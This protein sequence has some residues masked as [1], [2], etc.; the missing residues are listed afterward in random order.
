MSITKNM[1][2]G[3][4]T[5]VAAGEYT[6]EITNMRDWTGGQDGKSRKAQFFCEVAEP[7]KDAGKKVFFSTWYDKN[8]VTFLEK[9]GHSLEEIFGKS[10]EIDEEKLFALLKGRFFS[11]RLGVKNGYNELGEILACTDTEPKL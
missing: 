6:L 3:D 11:V 5:P 1:L 4:R 9:A 8:I 10:E 2:A 7:V